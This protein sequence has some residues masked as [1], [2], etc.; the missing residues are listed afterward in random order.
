MSNASHDSIDALDDRSGAL[1]AAIDTAARF[2]QDATG[3]LILAGAGMGVDSS[4]PDFRGDAGFWRAYPVLRE[5][6]LRLVDVAAPAMFEHDPVLAWGFYGHRLMLYRE[7]APHAGFAILRRWGETMPDGWWVSTTNVDG[8][9]QKAG[10]DVRYI[11][12]VHGTLHQL[13]CARPCCD[14]TWPASTLQ[15]D[16]GPDLRWQTAWPTCRRCAGIARPNVLMFGDAAWIGTASEAAHWQLVGWLDEVERL[17][18]VE[19]GAGTAIP[20]LRHFAEQL[21]EH[22]GAKLVR[23]N[24]RESRTARP[25]SIGLPLG[26]LDSL[27]LVDRALDGRGFTPPRRAG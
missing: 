22:R 12:E 23:I 26:A 8:Q 11:H 5:A 9:F 4:L 21:V 19:I 10:F 3:L 7:T 27:R 20:T 24:P 17:V 18:V 1:S 13:Q 6:R 25:G 16:I 15:P 14:T 2:I